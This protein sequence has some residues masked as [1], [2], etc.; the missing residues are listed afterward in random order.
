MMIAEESSAWHD[1]GD[2]PWKR[3]LGGDG[4]QVE[5]DPRNA[6]VVYTGF[7]FGN[8]FRI[9]RDTEKRTPIQPKHTLGEAPYRFNWQTPILLSPHNADIL[10]LGGNK[11]HRSMDRGDTW[12]AISDDLTRGGKK[13]NVAYGTLTTLSESPMQFGLLYTGSD[14]GLV[15]ITKD[16]GKNWENITSAGMPEWMMINSVEIDPFNKGGLYIAGTKYKSG[17]YGPGVNFSIAE[18][19]VKPENEKTGC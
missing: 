8:Y 11:L 12:T 3:L 9:E 16:G 17:D 5:V 1:T 18:S 10:Y 14:D 19:K 7:Q 15:H 13:G 2:Y 4:M 6:N